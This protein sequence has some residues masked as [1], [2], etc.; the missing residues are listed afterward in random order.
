MNKRKLIGPTIWTLIIAAPLML[1]FWNYDTTPEL[2]SVQGETVDWL[3]RLEFTIA[4]FF[5]ALCVV[6]FCYALFAFRRR[7]GDKGEGLHFHSNTALEIAWTFIP[8]VIVLSIA[9]LGF[10]NLSVLGFEEGTETMEIEV[11]G[12]QW[13]WRF[14]YPEQPEMGI[15]QA[16]TTTELY[17]PIDQPIHFTTHTDD[18]IH[19]FWIPE[20]RTKADAIPG[21]INEL[22][23]TPSVL[24]S[25]EVRCAELCGTDHAGMISPAEVVEQ[26]DFVA[27]VDNEI[28]IANDPSL[29]GLAVAKQYG[30]IGCHSPDGTE[31][32]GPTWQGLYESERVFDDGT[33]V[34][35][36]DD[37]LRD[38]ILY[39]NEQIVEGYA[40]NIMPM[41]F[42]ERMTPEEIEEVILYIHGLSGEQ[43]EAGE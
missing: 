33:E 39:P 7:T 17:L 4:A 16:I 12:F 41:D 32:A 9:F 18:V 11:T 6:F 28:A 3:L 27:W 10:Q 2:A 38:S 29:K 21:R 15:S 14:H 19:S 20:L 25:Y 30:C 35:A 8:L 22:N 34:I 1:Y 26:N 42:G 37:Y 24:G 31:L 36:D 43:S 5:F 40:A 23:L 13:A